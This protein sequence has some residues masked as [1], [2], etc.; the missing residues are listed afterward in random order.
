MIKKIAT[1]SL[2]ALLAGCTTQ[3]TPASKQSTI[4]QAQQQENLVKQNAMVEMDKFIG[5]IKPHLE[6]AL[7]SDPT[8][9]SGMQMCATSAMT[10]TDD[11]NKKIMPN[12]KVRRT[13]IK[14]RNELNKPDST[15]SK[16]MEQIVAS[17]QMKPV[18]VDMG[19][20][21]RVYKPLGTMPACV[22]CHGDVATMHKDTV[23]KIK[24]F[25]PKDK[26]TGFKVGDFRGVVVAEVNKK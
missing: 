24:Q 17:K 13:A 3:S 25:Y 2:F 7:K 9:A 1:I 22:V 18:V 11:Y 14:Y 20:K 15:D 26:A 23:S 21:Y 10:L 16:V 5:T 6:S 8:G 19:D 12:M 4:S